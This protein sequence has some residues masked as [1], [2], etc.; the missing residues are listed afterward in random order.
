MQDLFYEKEYEP[1]A[2]ERDRMVCEDLD[3]MGVRISVK[4]GFLLYEP[5]LIARKAAGGT[6]PRTM[7]GFITLVDKLGDPELPEDFSDLA[8]PE[9]GHVSEDK[10][11]GFLDTPEPAEFGFEGEDEKREQTFPGGEDAGLKRMEY[12]MKREKGRVVSRFAKPETSPAAISPRDTTL[13]SPYLAIG[14]LS[15]R[16]FHA[17]LREIEERLG[18][19][20]M[21]QT[22]LRGQLLWREHF[23]HLAYT[24]KNFDRM[25]GNVLCRQMEWDA[26]E[27][28]RVYLK[29]WEEA[30]TGYPWIDALMTQL[31]REGFVH[32]LGRHSLACFLTRGD[33]FVSWEHGFRV[34]EKFLVDYDYALNSANWMWLSASAF[35][36][37]YF[38]VYSPVAFA[39]KWDKDG[40][41]VR[42]YLPVL[43]DMPTKWIHEPWKAPRAV[44]ERARC[45]V[46]RDYAERIVKH[47][48][49]LK[50]NLERMKTAY[51]KKEYGTLDDADGDDEYG[52][53]RRSGGAPSE[54]DV[55]NE[56]GGLAR[57][58]RQDRKRRRRA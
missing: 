32:H 37:K 27:E 17:R 19:K 46:G 53:G 40:E 42:H 26:D 7:G 21:V 4:Q 29:R 33:L 10:K 52:A 54:S 35:F 6:A 39:K 41:F 44:Q 15:C 9:D 23:W 55:Q 12:F 43:K 57:E 38:R 13:L 2:I 47:E 18:V 16:V 49:V 45:I 11:E 24:T 25:K 1:G 22:T 51:A 8:V 56:A 36:N 28:W 5:E 31:R 30:R 14:A 20:D 34:F 50:R 3:G 48:E 58:S